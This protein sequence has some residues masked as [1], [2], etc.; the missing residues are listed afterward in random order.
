MAKREEILYLIDI[1]FAGREAFGPRGG[2]VCGGM[3]VDR[4]VRVVIV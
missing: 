3:A 1:F 2:A 4:A